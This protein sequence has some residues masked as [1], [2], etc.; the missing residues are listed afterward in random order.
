[1][2][3]HRARLSRGGAIVGPQGRQTPPLRGEECGL[4][5]GGGGE[6]GDG[7][8]QQSCSVPA[9]APAGMA[10]SPG[11]AECRGGTA[12]TM[13]GGLWLKEA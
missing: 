13:G 1:M 6:M 10:V 11:R 8:R 7:R 3:E 9:D 12:G 4:T 2:G 5:R